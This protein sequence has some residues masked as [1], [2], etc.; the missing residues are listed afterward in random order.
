M[1]QQIQRFS[2]WSGF[3][4]LIVLSSCAAPAL[5]RDYRNITDQ[6]ATGNDKQLL[7]NLARMYM[8][9]PV[10]F[11]QLGSLSSQYQFTTSAGFSPTSSKTGP[12]GAMANV[13][14]HTL[15]FGGNLNAGVTATPIFQFLPLAGSN[16]VQAILTP[17]S[18]KVFYTFYDQ[19]FPA[20]LLARTM[21]EGVEKRN[22]DGSILT[23]YVNH[24]ENATYPEFLEF[25]DVLRYAQL[26]YGLN[27]DTNTNAVTI[28]RSPISGT[29]NKLADI[30][31]ALQAGLL[32]TDECSDLVV[33]KA[34]Q[35]TLVPTPASS[36]YYRVL[37]ATIRRRGVPSFPDFSTGDIT[38]LAAFINSA[39]EPSNPIHELWTNVMADQNAQ[40]ALNVFTN[41]LQPVQAYVASVLTNIINGRVGTNKVTLCQNIWALISNEI[42]TN[43]ESGGRMKA[44]DLVLSNLSTSILAEFLQRLE[45]KTSSMTD[46]TN[47]SADYWTIMSNIWSTP[48]PYLTNFYSAVT[49][50]RS[51]AF[52]ALANSLTNKD[53]FTSG[54]HNLQLGKEMEDFLTNHQSEL[55]GQCVNRFIIENALASALSVTTD[56]ERR[57]FLDTA[58]FVIEYRD[59]QYT[60][61]LRTFESVLYAL[62]HEQEMFKR[63]EKEKPRYSEIT[64]VENPYGPIAK[65]HR[66]G[67]HSFQVRPILVIQYDNEARSNLAILVEVED[68]HGQLFTIGDFDE[69]KLKTKPKIDPGT[70]ETANRTVF[71]VVS[72]LFGQA[73][74]STQNL[75]VQQL[76]QVQ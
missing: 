28:L 56:D 39:K 17:I 65:V 53:V 59:G 33:K 30:T 37:M 63:F 49:N 3:L 42:P 38:N 40:E 43:L 76:I 69:N 22:P 11:V 51:A 16:F 12:I 32:V 7:F 61:K 47:I 34:D 10:Y 4:G 18:D 67:G 21:V 64:F 57:T 62:A 66:H 50:L 70:P 31:G 2:K 24:P 75:P 27:V 52:T 68:T 29:N 9:S 19:D 45:S 6:Y 74:I 54:F 14:Q 44:C 35:R 23:T 13:F 26:S 8:H 48:N 36:N 58:K 46:K 72:Y 5:R 15:T 25:C 41:Q 20:D 55:I 71:T 1:R 60:F 73:S